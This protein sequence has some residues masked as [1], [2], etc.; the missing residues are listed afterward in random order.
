MT[1]TF[2]TTAFQTYAAEDFFETPSPPQLQQP[3]PRRTYQPIAPNPT[4]IP[5][6]SAPKRPREEDATLKVEPGSSSPD[7][8][9]N[10]RKRRRTNSATPIA[11]KNLS[12]DE[13]YL[14]HLKQTEDLPWKDIVA[15]FKDDRGKVYTEAALQMKNTRMRQ[16]SRP[17]EEQDV[18][19]LEEACKWWEKRK[20]RFIS[21][22]VCFRFFLF[23]FFLV[24]WHANNSS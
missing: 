14:L 10:K 9:S 12:E 3:Q 1:S 7:P 22:K 13:T 11:T 4:P 16:R 21:E 6:A 17:W 24:G 23:R 8:T 5:S 20:W 15:R 19:A 2:P 18:Y